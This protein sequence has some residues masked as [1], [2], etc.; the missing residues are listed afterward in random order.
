MLDVDGFGHVPVDTDAIESFTV[1]WRVMDDT[2][3]N[4][5]GSASEALAEI[6]ARALLSSAVGAAMTSS[7]GDD[8]EA[9]VGAFTAGDLVR[10]ARL[11]GMPAPPRVISAP[12]IRSVLIRGGHKAVPLPRGRGRD[13]V[14]SLHRA[15]PYRWHIAADLREVFGDPNGAR[16]VL[17][18]DPVWTTVTH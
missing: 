8:M 13:L 3:T 6:A 16:A 5:P 2:L 15:V 18:C 9:A 4:P 14:P 7:H 10:L 17:D 11:S 1:L 12:Y